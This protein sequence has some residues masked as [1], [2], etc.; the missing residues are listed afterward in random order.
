[1]GDSMGLSFFLY[2]MGFIAICGI[3]REQKTL[4][5]GSFAFALVWPLTT[6]IWL[7]FRAADRLRGQ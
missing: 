4:D 1:M 2:A 7:G 5:A 3:Q 6:L